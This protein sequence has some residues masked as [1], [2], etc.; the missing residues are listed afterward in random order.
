MADTTRILVVGYG[1]VGRGVISAI[2]RN[3]DME[4][5]GVMTRRPD[6]VEKELADKCRVFKLSNMSAVSREGIADVAVLC[7]GSKQDLPKYGPK[8]ARYISTVDS[9]DTHANIPQYFAKMDKIAHAEGNVVIISAGW[10]P[11]TFSLERVLGDSFLPDSK[12]YT[13]WGPGVSQG[14]SDAVRKIAGVKDA[15]QYTLPVEG[16][17]NSVRTGANPD[18]TTREKHRRLVY[19]VAE[20][21][22][23]KELARIQ[24]EIVSMPNYF[25]DYDTEVRF[26]GTEEM[27]QEHSAYPHGGF[28]L[29][30]GET[31]SGNKAMIEYKNQWA[32]NPE[33]TGSI[34]VACARAARRFDRMKLYGA[35]TML[36]IPPNFYSPRSRKDL[37]KHFM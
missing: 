6:V 4:L 11:G 36:D 1:N 29:T 17:L 24:Q 21:S 14:H 13:F 20:S 34:L 12:K 35:Y 2:A 16:A 22:D 26:I 18:L 31:G 10:D 33:A 30:A 7:G 23:P 25:V 37:L 28:V 5:A 3:P 8:M 15:R 9:F 19:V 27:K 32:S